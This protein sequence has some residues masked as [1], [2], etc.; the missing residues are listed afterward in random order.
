MADV[1]LGHGHH[2]YLSAIAIVL[3]ALSTIFLS[4]RLYSRFSRRSG[5]AGA[6][7]VFL[8]VGWVVF[9]GYGNLLISN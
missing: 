4:L 9:S 2:F 6:D 7:D 3:Q 5:K 8:V 1:A